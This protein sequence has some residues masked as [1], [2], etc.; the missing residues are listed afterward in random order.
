MQPPCKKSSSASTGARAQI[1]SPSH[2][3]RPQCT[4]ENSQGHVWRGISHSSDLTL[5]Q[6]RR[7]LLVQAPSRVSGPSCLCHPPSPAQHTPRGCTSQGSH[8]SAFSPLS[9]SYLA[10]GTGRESCALQ[11]SGPLWE[12]RGTGQWGRLWPWNG[13]IFG[14]VRPPDRD[15]HTTCAPACSPPGNSRSNDRA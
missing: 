3:P 9:T 8:G 1:L 13:V 15:H 10:A 5:H 11:R 7:Y 4:P 14:G 6:H 12:T 2:R